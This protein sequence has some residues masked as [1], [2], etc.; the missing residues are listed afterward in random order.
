MKAAMD[1][2][3]ALLDLIAQHPGDV[4]HRLVYADWLEQHGDPRSEAVRSACQYRMPF[5]RKELKFVQAIGAARAEAGEPVLVEVDREAP[6]FSIDSDGGLLP[7]SAIEGGG[8]RE[9]HADLDRLNPVA[10]A[11]N[12]PRDDRGNLLLNCAVLLAQYRCLSDIGRD[13]DLFLFAAAPEKRRDEQAIRIQ[14]QPLIGV[15]QPHDWRQQR[16]C[17][18]LDQASADET[19]RWGVEREVIDLCRFEDGAVLLA[20]LSTISPD[21]LTDVQRVALCTLL[22]DAGR[23]EEAMALCDVQVDEELTRMLN[24]EEF[25]LQGCCDCM[26]QGAAPIRAGRLRR[27]LWEVAPWKFANAVAQEQQVLDAWRSARRG[28]PRKQAEL[29]L[30]I[31]PKQ[32]HSRRAT[33]VLRMGNQGLELTFVASASNAQ[34]AQSFWKRPLEMDILRFQ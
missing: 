16:W 18:D 3:Q 10:I 23:F 8:L 1:D 30:F 17:W 11:Q 28:R 21:E 13:R 25:P 5:A 24:A 7:F 34:A 4:T 19:I 9:F 14:L 2:E 20:E 12:F 6:E 29:R 33:L 22:Q 15:N 26:H 31:V 27:E 32:R